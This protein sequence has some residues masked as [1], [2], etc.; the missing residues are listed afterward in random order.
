MT[1]S[2]SRTVCSTDLPDAD[3]LRRS[4]LLSIPGECSLAAETSRRRG[5]K[6]HNQHAVGQPVSS[7][8]CA[9][10]I[11]DVAI[12]TTPGV[13]LSVSHWIDWH[14]PIILRAN[15]VKIF[16]DTSSTAFGES[17]FGE[18][19]PMMSC[20]NRWVSAKNRVARCSI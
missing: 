17:N 5:R 3:M 6:L 15:C 16:D 18:V 20:C 14:A 4:Q 1:I 9:F 12:A 19:D 2:E 10:P 11:D 8:R 7:L 13:R